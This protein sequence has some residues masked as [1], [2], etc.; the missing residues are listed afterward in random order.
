MENKKISVIVPIYNKEDYLL[1][2]IDSILKQTYSNLEII[3]VD[4]GS[5]DSSKAICEK[6]AKE[7]KRILYFN[8]RHTGAGAARN[9]GLEKSTGE[10]ISFID[11]DDYIV[12]NYYR[13]M[14]QMIETTQSDLAECAFRRIQSK[15][16]I[17]DK[18]NV[19]VKVLSNVEK[20]MELY[21]EDEDIYVNSV[22]MCN[23]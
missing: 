10:F 8:T 3:L 6:K 14:M 13:I 21:G 11:A 7:D 20:L 9:L 16:E 17:E 2:C 19:E 18:D 1:V 22:I 12:P 5:T 23:K 4:D 15:E